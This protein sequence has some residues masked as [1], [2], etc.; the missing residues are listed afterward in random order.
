MV[1]EFEYRQVKGEVQVIYS[2]ISDEEGADQIIREV[3]RTKK[4][5]LM[6]CEEIWVKA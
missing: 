5:S 2:G 1:R 4:K 3:M 6:E